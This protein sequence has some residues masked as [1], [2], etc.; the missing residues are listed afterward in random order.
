M[1]EVHVWD[2]VQLQWLLGESQL[3]RKQAAEESPLKGLQLSVEPPPK[4]AA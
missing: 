4:D 1:F 3:I 2:S